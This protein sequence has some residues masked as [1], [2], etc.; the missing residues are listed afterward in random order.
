MFNVIGM[1]SDTLYPVVKRRPPP[2]TSLSAPH[3]KE[4]KYL[5]TPGTNRTLVDV[6]DFVSEEEEDLADAQS[7]INDMLD[8]AKAWWLLE[9]I[10]QKVKHQGDDDAWIRE[11]L[12]DLRHAKLRPSAVWL[13]NHFLR[14]NRGRGR[15]IPKQHAGVKIHR[16]V[17]LRMEN[18]KLN[19]SPKAKWSAD[20]EP[21][22]VD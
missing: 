15:D 8:I 21:E 11:V 22:W 3:E 10:P 14:I 5:P 19:Y 17:K 4:V 12:W 7:D 18:P 6:S 20:V 13:M 1:D 16:S 2:V 9:Y